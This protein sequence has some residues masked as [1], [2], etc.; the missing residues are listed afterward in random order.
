[1]AHTR[2]AFAITAVLFLAAM[3]FMTAVSDDQYLLISLALVLASM[4]PFFIRFEVRKMQAREIVL[5]AVMAAIAAV[6]RVPFAPLPS[7]QPTSFVIIVSA[8]VFGAE[9]G[10]MIGAFAAL[11]SN[12]FLGQ[13]PWTPWQMFAWGMMGWT[14]GLLNRGGLLSS[15]RW[16]LLLFGAGWGMLF[17]WIMNFWLAAGL[18]SQ[19]DWEAIAALYA[20]SL[21]FDLAHAGSNVFFL[22][23]FAASWIK[24]LQ[25]F[26]RKYGLLQPDETL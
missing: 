14:A 15:S 7:V 9:S 5:I 19:H 18:L 16:L 22:L 21:Y 17:G 20:S 11:V 24:I 1:M 6:G 3:G 13:G 10:F 12:M 8:L 26:K 25:R 23:L 2:I 4:L